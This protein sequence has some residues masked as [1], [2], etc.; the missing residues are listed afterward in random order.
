MS[1]WLQL[2]CSVMSW[3]FKIQIS[4]HNCRAANTLFL[5]RLWIGV[6]CDFYLEQ[7]Y[8]TISSSKRNIC[9]QLKLN[10]CS[11][12]IV[13][14]S[15]LWIQ[16]KCFYSFFEVNIY[17]KQNAFG[18]VD[19]EFQCKNHYRT[20]SILRLARRLVRFYFKFSTFFFTFLEFNF[21]K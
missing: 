15:A 20:N 11:D 6:C 2:R 21:S 19:S 12:R 18:F 13:D 17:I 10:N 7:D 14:F 5:S 3:W 8:K 4:I 1:R 16:I 9:S